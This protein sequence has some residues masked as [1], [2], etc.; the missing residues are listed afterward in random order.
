MEPE[1][2]HIDTNALD[3]G[4]AAEDTDTV[5]R[6]R[7][8]A[9]EGCAEAQGRLGKALLTGSHGLARDPPKAVQLLTRAAEQGHA[10]AQFT[11][12]YL[13]A[14]E[15]ISQN[16]QEAARPADHTASRSVQRALLKHQS[17]NP[18][19]AIAAAR[20]LLKEPPVGHNKRKLA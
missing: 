2:T 17:S 19:R 1:S 15:G 11:L 10:S 9:A 12:G 6:W 4:T 18:G 7:L 3:A 14:I 8:E 13:N 16:L 5:R 20:A